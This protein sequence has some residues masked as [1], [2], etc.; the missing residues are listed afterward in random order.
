ML[1]SLRF[2]LA[3][4]VLA[5]LSLASPAF[6][7]AKKPAPAAAA[8]HK[9]PKHAALGKK[10]TS[11]VASV[12]KK[13]TEKAPTKG[14]AKVEKKTDPKDTKDLK[15]DLKDPKK[16]DAKA[17]QPPE[18]M[19]GH[20][21]QAK[22]ADKKKSLKK[23]DD[24]GEKSEKVEKVEKK[25]DKLDKKKPLLLPHAKGAKV[26]GLEFQNLQKK[27]SLSDKEKKGSKIKACLHPAVSFARLG[28]PTDVTFSLTT[29]ANGTAPG[30]VDALSVLARPYDVPAPTAMTQ[31]SSVLSLQKKTAKPSKALSSELDEVAPGIR[32]IDPGMVTRLQAISDKFPGKT[33]TLVS[34]YRPASKGS[35]HQSARAF[36]IRLDGVTNESLVSFC[37][38]LQDTGC[39]YYPN[40]YFVHVDVR[41]TGV[42]HVFWIDTSG[43]G[44]KPVY[45][46]QWPPPLPAAKA[47]DPKV[48]K[49]EDPTASGAA[50]T[51][52]AKEIGPLEDADEE[53]PSTMTAPTN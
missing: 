48:E 13:L 24:K 29:C 40:S 49:T 22:I 19:S 14:E 50:P 25:D 33:I 32:R 39:G 45:V 31:P 35:P 6:A 26:S 12:T 20:F 1:S 2:P 43:P 28:Q 38:T 42:G 7:E 53:S 5:S 21:P 30:A 51:T 41:K 27:G 46:K 18:E 4:L 34:G 9:P 37:K 52:D 3:S 15:K 8:T 44:E 17:E 47:T 16:I 36:D 11:K 10:H 23:D